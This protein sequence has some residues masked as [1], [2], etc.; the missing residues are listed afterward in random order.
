MGGAHSSPAGNR[1]RRGSDPGHSG[2]KTIAAS[3][4]RKPAKEGDQFL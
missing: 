3:W 4:T 2:T 1:H